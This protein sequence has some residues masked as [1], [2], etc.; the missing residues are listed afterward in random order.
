[1]VLRIYV[2]RC[3]WCRRCSTTHKWL[4][5]AWRSCSVFWLRLSGSVSAKRD[6]TFNPSPELGS[7]QLSSATPLALHAASV[8]KDNLRHSFEGAVLPCY[9]DSAGNGGS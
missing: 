9:A 4:T 6:Q 8:C 2:M 7:T 1:M 3:A 5:Y